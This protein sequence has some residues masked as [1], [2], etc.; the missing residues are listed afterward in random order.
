MDG[1]DGADGFDFQDKLAGDDN[2]R[3]DAVADFCALIEDGNC[4]LPGEG[5][6]SIRQFSAQAQLIY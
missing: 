5:N 6:T 4:D 2:I 3:L 1:Q